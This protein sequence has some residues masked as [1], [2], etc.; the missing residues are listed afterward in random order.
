MNVA[1]VAIGNNL[2]VTQI[3]VQFGRATRTAHNAHGQ[4]NFP[5]GNF[6]VNRMPNVRDA[7]YCYGRL[8]GWFRCGTRCTRNAVQANNTVNI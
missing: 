6:L 1:C 2:W 4:Q 5:I 7:Y 8:D 3:P